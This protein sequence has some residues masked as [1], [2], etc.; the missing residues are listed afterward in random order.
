[1]NKL[2][3]KYSFT[4]GIILFLGLSE[5]LG[6]GL[7]I[8]GTVT[9][10]DGSTLPG[11]NISVIGT[12]IGSVSD[13]NGTYTVKNLN[14][15]SKLRFSFVGYKTVDLTVGAKSKL[16]VILKRDDIGL[17]EVVVVGYGSVKKSDLTGSVSTIK[18]SEL[19]Q[20]PIVSLD[21]GLQGRAPGVQVTQNSG[22]PGGAVSIRI[23]GGNSIS[24]SNEPLYVIDGFPVSGAVVSPSGPGFGANQSN[25]MNALAGLNPNDIESLEVL[26]D[27]AATSIYGSRGANGVVLITTKRGKSGKTKVEIESY[28]GMQ[29]VNRMLPLMNGEQ[30][31]A[32]ENELTPG[33]FPAVGTYGEGTNWQ[34]ELFSDAPINSNQITVSG[35]SEKTQFSV[36]TNYFTQDGIIKGSDFKRGSF[37]VNLDHQLNSKVKFGSNLSLSK[38]NSNVVNNAQENGVTFTALLMSPLVPVY[39]S[40]G[41]YTNP[42]EYNSYYAGTGSAENPLAMA[43]YMK[44]DYNTL[45]VL[46]NVFSE[47]QILKNLSYRFSLGTDVYNDTRNVFIPR[48]TQAGKAVNGSGGRGIVDQFTYLH[49][50]VLNWNPNI[51]KNHT[52]NVTGV[53]STQSQSQVRSGLS[54]SNFP[55]DALAENNLSI[56]ATQTTSTNKSLWRLDSYTARVNY[57]YKER[58]LLSLTT[59][60]DGSSRFGDGNKYGFFPSLAFAWRVIEEDFMKQQDIFS[61]LKI[62]LSYGRTGNAEVPLYQSLFKLGT[63]GNFDY[64]FNNSRAVGIG[65]QGI[66]NPDLK[67]ENTESYNAGLDFGVFNNRLNFNVDAYY[68]LTSDLLLGRTIPASSGFSSFF[69]NFGQVENKGLEFGLTGV[70]VNR[71]DFTWNVSSN[72]SFNRNKLV[73]LDG[74]QTQI[75][76]A[77]NS[78]GNAA[79]SNNSVLRIGEPVGSFFG[80]VFDGIWQKTDNIATS[81]MPS[82]IPGN[83][84]YKDVNGDNKLTDADRVIIGNPNPDFIYAFST[85]MTYKKF[86][87]SLFMQGVQGNQVFNVVSRLLETAGGGGNQRAEMVN[88]WTPTNPS[89]SYIVASRSQRLPQ[90]NKF[91]EDGSFLRLKNISVGYTIVQKSQSKIRLYFSANNLFTITKYWGFDPEVNTAGQSDVTNYGI[92]NGGFPVAKSLIAGLQLT[93]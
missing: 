48:T 6:Q 5:M 68:K 8:T 35:G 7:N 50:S 17:D 34:K 10:D 53:F 9:S 43:Q 18:A 42:V 14:S 88:R 93:F 33:R 90:S 39:N 20:T 80:Y 44:N 79:F 74:N 65:A 47:I 11:V 37:R 25:G 54:A 86:D 28:Y 85:N 89:N 62:R 64:V 92:D 77:E 82:S 30:Y 56:A 75:I 55:S 66:P 51:G 76:P 59:R 41:F 58:Y 16:D 63:T 2:L 15:T 40:Q 26:K 23:R 22:A 70:I 4:I 19:K 73:K 45:R 57:N 60:L 67:W 32:F 31:A 78:G 13:Q 38:L 46:G 69:G 24:S 61:D 27:A 81:H 72:I 29:S 21:Q 36:A 1:M 87:M 12:N 91:I 83:S 52:L 49:E 3:L 84:R 71:N